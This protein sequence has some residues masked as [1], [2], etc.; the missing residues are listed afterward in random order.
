MS[1]V[2]VSNDTELASALASASAGQAIVL[3]D[4][5]YSAFTL[6]GGSLN[7]P[8]LT[9]KAENPNGATLLGTTKVINFSGVSMQGLVFQAVEPSGTQHSV[10]ATASAMEVINSANVDLSGNT[11]QGYKIAQTITM[12]GYTLTP[13]NG[14]LGGQGLQIRGSD[15]VKVSGNE[16]TD[17]LHGVSFVQDT[18]GRFG[19]STNTVIENN[20]FHAIRVDGIR[21]TDHDNTLVSQNF[22][23]NFT[24]FQIDP[25]D[26]TQEPKDHSDFIQFWAYK[27]SG[28]QNAGVHNFTIENNL[29]YDPYG[30]S[31]GVFGHMSN[32][33]DAERANVSFDNFYIK[34]NVIVTAV[35]NAITLGSVNGG[36]ISGNTLL[37]NAKTYDGGSNA[38]ININSS[39]RSTRVD[40]PAQIQYSKNLAIFG[41]ISSDYWLDG[42]T[43]RTVNGEIYDELGVYGVEHDKNLHLV[44]NALNITDGTGQIGVNNITVSTDPNAPNYIGSASLFPG[45]ADG[46][47][48]IADILNGPNG[49]AAVPLV[50]LNNLAEIDAESKALAVA[51][52]YAP[53]TTP[54]PTVDTSVHAG[55][56]G[57]TTG[58]TGATTDTSGTTTD[59]SDTSTDT[60]VTDTGTSNAGTDTTGAS[61]GT[62]GAT[63]ASSGTSGSTTD[64]SGTQTDV[65]GSSH[66]TSGSSG[67]SGTPTYGSSSGTAY[68]VDSLIFYADNVISGTDHNRDRRSEVISGTSQSDLIYGYG[69]NDKIYGGGGDDYIAAGTGRDAHVQG[70]AGADIFEFGFGDE[71]IKIYDWQDGVD[72]IHLVGGLTYDDLNVYVSAYN[73]QTSIQLW[74]DVN[75]DGVM[76]DRLILTNMTAADLGTDDFV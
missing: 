45:L 51:M 20:Y 56:G 55:S 25:T 11:F 61:K 7:A 29:M 71:L 40:D 1:T 27:S 70:G 76:D 59:T 46:D 18:G 3:K 12:S 9:I 50:V 31:A 60:S 41:N 53:S 66:T 75:G 54:V 33:T 64:T 4:G 17:L 22:F 8:G 37:P 34:N 35:I 43:F 72:K 58:T 23:G 42:V 69:G 10:A 6:D 44:Y 68:D 19:L 24:P 57:S 74:T 36:E 67:S 16:F 73:N 52:G 28:A 21:G 32:L 63:G 30:Q 48:S 15:S 39:E 49:T 2:I 5:T 65:D 38:Y 13:D 26:L 14:L 47:T 62:S